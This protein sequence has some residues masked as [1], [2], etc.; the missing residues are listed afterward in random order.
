MKLNQT[1]ATVTS[2]IAVAW[3]GNAFA[4]DATPTDQTPPA[5]PAEATPAAAS[6][7]EATP[8]E[9]A[10]AEATPPATPSEATP[11]E[12][13]PSPPPSTGELAPTPLVE[14]SPSMS[15][16]YVDR[17]APVEPLSQ[18]WAPASGFGMAVMA[19]GGVT[20]FTQG[21]TR[22]FTGTG[23]SWDARLAFGTR[24]WV[25]FEASYVGGANSI[26]NLG[27]ANNNTN[28]V[29]NGVEGMLRINAPLY[30]GNTLLEPYIGG[31]VGWNSYRVTNYN[32]NL[33]SASV[34]ANSDNTVSVPLA[35]GFAL[36]YKGFVVDARFTIRPTYSQT[37][38]TDESSSALTNWDVGGM[39]GYEF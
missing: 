18:R 12:A 39:L 26:H 1:I 23:G 37:L 35:A 8:A 10:P 7:S 38:L 32:A 31:G 5:S 14:P 21:N 28:L 13:A 6:P 24:T 34:S 22:G 4:Q 17:P 9:A 16:T 20:D 30:A 3:A 27:I 33:S 2:A 29:R 11:A 19:G 36:G 15:P 25:G